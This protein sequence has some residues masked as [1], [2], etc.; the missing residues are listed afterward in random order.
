MYD[1]CH[2]FMVA[3]MALQ[4]MHMERVWL[5]S[6][7][8]NHESKLNSTSLVWVHCRMFSLVGTVMEVMWCGHTL[9]TC[10]GQKSKLHSK[11]H[12]ISVFFVVRL[13]SAE[14]I[15]EVTEPWWRGWSIWPYSIAQYLWLDDVTK[16]C[17][18]LLL[19]GLSYPECVW[20]S[21]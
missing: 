13:C 5:Y 15:F 19:R 16:L 21:E 12:I 2:I 9:N 1:T 14:M 17:S 18:F 4:V 8:C 3:A 10:V 7:F 6:Y 20:L 11:H